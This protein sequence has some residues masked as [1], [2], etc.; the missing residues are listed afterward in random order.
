VE[1]RQ[2][3][4]LAVR[5]GGDGRRLRAI[6]KGI[7]PPWT[8]KRG[9]GRRRLCAR[10]RQRRRICRHLALDVDPRRK[11]L[12][13]QTPATSRTSCCS[14]TRRKRTKFLGRLP[15]Q[16]TAQ[17]RLAPLRNALYLLESRTS[18]PAVWSTV[19]SVLLPTMRRQIDQLVRM[20]DDLLDAARISQTKQ[21]PGGE[22]RRPTP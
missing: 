22:I 4:A 7:H 15:A 14:R 3:D 9:L 13:Q 1:Y 10:V 16:P 8:A 5:P 11:L 12:E 18:Q 17:C 21:D 6:R 19:D 2:I 20:V